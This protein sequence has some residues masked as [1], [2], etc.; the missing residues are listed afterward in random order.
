MNL[1]D[2]RIFGSDALS[3]ECIAQSSAVAYF[4]FKLAHLGLALSNARLCACSE[5]GNG[6]QSKQGKQDKQGTKSKKDAFCDTREKPRKWPLRWAAPTAHHKSF[7][8]NVFP[9]WGPR[10]DG[11]VN[12]VR[13]SVCSGA[14]F[15]ATPSATLSATTARTSMTRPHVCGVPSFLAPFLVLPF[16]RSVLL[17]TALFFSSLTCRVAASLVVP[18]VFDDA[19]APTLH[20]VVGAT[21][22]SHAIEPPAHQNGQ[23]AAVWNLKQAGTRAQV[24]AWTLPPHLVGHV[25][26]WA[27]ACPVRAAGLDAMLLYCPFFA[28]AGFIHQDWASG[29][30]PQQL[31]ELYI[32]SVESKAE[33][34]ESNLDAL[35]LPWIPVLSA[36]SSIPVL[37]GLVHPRFQTADS[38]SDSDDSDDSD[39]GEKESKANKSSDK[40]S[41]GGAVI[42]AAMVRI[43]MAFSTPGSTPG[44]TPGSTGTILQ[45]TTKTALK[46]TTTTQTKR[47]KD[48]QR[49]AEMRHQQTF[50][51][52]VLPESLGLA[53][54]LVVLSSASSTDASISAS[55]DIGT[56]LTCVLAPGHV[57]SRTAA[58]T[59][60]TAATAAVSA[61][62]NLQ[63]FVPW[64][65]Q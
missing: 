59:T 37:K 34:I 5:R 61:T 62:V 47:D 46:T 51:P 32:A 21:A 20:R 43:S 27:F 26:A 30:L 63:L 54:I 36:R 1:V 33:S 55:R 24:R 41:E 52:L 31:W 17:D 13:A 10:D 64:G 4:L 39:F 14:S 45:T 19:S 2:V 3:T 16:E 15:T 8:R 6:K 22:G 18:I 48:R 57:L 11:A 56:A 29:T 60:T 42:E 25:G 38:D 58:T 40:S 53:I 7:L 28:D 49:R 65:R 35:V 44:A 50:Q 9:S 23:I 12:C